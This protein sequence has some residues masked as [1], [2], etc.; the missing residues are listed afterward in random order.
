V[1]RFRITSKMLS[2]TVALAAVGALMVTSA[3]D[4]EAAFKLRLTELG[5][6]LAVG[7][8]GAD[9]DTVVTIQDGGGNDESGFAGVIQYTQSIGAFDVN[10]NI[11][12]SKPAL[13]SATTP[14]IHLTNMQLQLTPGVGG[15][16][17]IAL[18]DTGFESASSPLFFITGFGGAGTG[19]AS[20]ESY[21]SP[22]NGEFSK[23]GT[24][25]GDFASFGD[26]QSV[27]AAVD[28]E[29]SI[30]LFGTVVL[31]SSIFGSA[32][33]FDA[34]V[35]VPEPQTLALFGLGL[36]GLGFMARRR[37]ANRFDV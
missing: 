26:N 36:L 29:Y 10:V 17:M 25:I 23:T 37:K 12:S 4:A 27:Y 7:G 6:D 18:T 9:A 2:V 16:I 15:A 13:G 11:G 21:V 24:Q 5:A 19:S 28:G 14:I 1:E 32:L 34:T 22:D 30:S 33:S 31:P 20:F 35:R 3:N 8:V